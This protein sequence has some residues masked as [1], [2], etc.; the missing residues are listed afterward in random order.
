M[1]MDFEG[2]VHDLLRIQAF[3]KEKDNVRKKNENPNENVQ[4][5]TCRRKTRLK[6]EI[7]S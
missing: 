6:K 7:E 5:K 1:F 3:K 4:K 2:K